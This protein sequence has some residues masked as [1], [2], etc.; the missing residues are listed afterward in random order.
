MPTAV[1][2]KHTAFPVMTENHMAVVKVLAF[3]RGKANAVIAKI[4]LGEI[5]E[6]CP[7]SRITTTRELRDLKLE[8]NLFFGAYL[9]SCGDGY[10]MA[11]TEEDITAVRNYYYSWI[12]HMAREAKAIRRNFR[13]NRLRTQLRLF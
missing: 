2:E 10:Y 12:K 7:L 8:L 13:E 6:M 3:H 1:A 11:E 9:C 4:L 5:A